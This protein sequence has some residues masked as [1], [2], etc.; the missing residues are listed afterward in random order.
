VD[1]FAL[2]VIPDEIWYVLPAKVVLRLK[3]NIRLAP[4]VEGQ[5][6]QRYRE[7]WGLLERKVRNSR[8][9]RQK[10]GMARAAARDLSRD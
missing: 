7:A 4:G 3:S 1:F 9:Q 8:K 2:Y 10:I 5:K 6:Y